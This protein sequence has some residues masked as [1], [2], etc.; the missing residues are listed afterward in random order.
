MAQFIIDLPNNRQGNV[1]TEI[2]KKAKKSFKNLF[3]PWKKIN[4]EEKIAYIVYVEPGY[5]INEYHF[6]K[7]KE[8]KWLESGEDK[9]LR[10]GEGTFNMAIKKA[11]DEYENGQ[12]KQAV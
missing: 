8:G 5:D 3:S 12:R 11:I 6:L 10:E 2:M 4:N 1:K 7:T 9:W